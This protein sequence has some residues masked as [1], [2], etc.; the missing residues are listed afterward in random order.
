RAEGR[1]AGRGAPDGGGAGAPLPR[2]AGDRGPAVPR[3][4]GQRRRR[5]APAR[6]PVRPSA[7]RR[8]RP[9][10]PQ[11]GPQ[12]DGD[13]RV[14]ER[15]RPGRPL[16]WCRKVCTRQLGRLKTFFKWAESEEHV[17]RGTW[18][19]LQTVPGLEAGEAGVRETDDVLPIPEG[20]LPRIVA[21]LNPVVSVMVRV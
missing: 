20:H 4:A 16:S 14:D 2:R 3:G 6:S 7:P 13:L 18:H 8:R 10:G 11:D 17:P 5:P 21:Q 1:P 15:G 19:A 12:R 9:E